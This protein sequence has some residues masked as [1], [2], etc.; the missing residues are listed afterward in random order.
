MEKIISLTEFPN[1]SLLFGNYNANI[2]LMRDSFNVKIVARD[3]LKV[4]GED[5][6]VER[7]ILAIEQINKKIVDKGTISSNE[8]AEIIQNNSDKTNFDKSSFEENEKDFAI[9]EGKKA[10]VRNQ[11]LV[12]PRTPGQNLYLQAMHDHEIVFAIGPSGTGKTFLAVA[13]A[14]D[15]LKRGMVR[16]I[17][18]VRPAVEAGERLG[19]LPGDY[20]AKVNP[21]LRPLYDSLQN[22]LD[23]NKLRTYTEND[24]IE[25]A[26]LAYMRGRTLDSAFIILDEAQNTTSTQMK[27][28]LTRLGRNSRIVITG[29]VTQIDLPKGERSGLVHAQQILSSVPGLGF[30]YL[31]KEDIVRHH[32]VQQIIAAY[33]ANDTSS[34]NNR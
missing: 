27:M 3:N 31:T 11:P 8:V 10:G 26:P 12:K 32:L 18:L 28:L 23:F 25:V 29:D 13:V 6:D 5:K 33:D 34:I 22:L 17:V 24:I 15:F 9:D 1:V 16:K 2:K 19:F 20:Q 4:S 14:I 7:T 21:Y 30:V